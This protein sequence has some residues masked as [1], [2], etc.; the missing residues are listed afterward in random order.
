VSQEEEVVGAEGLLLVR[1]VP[2]QMASHIAGWTPSL[3]DWLSE[4]LYMAAVA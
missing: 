1:M 2:L 3:N 4:S